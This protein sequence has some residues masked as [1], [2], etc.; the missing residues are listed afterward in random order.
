MGNF[1][2]SV[3][4]AV[5][6][7]FYLGPISLQANSC[8]NVQKYKIRAARIKQMSMGMARSILLIRIYCDSVMQFVYQLLIL[9]ENIYK[10]LWNYQLR[11]L[12]LPWSAFSFS[13][14]GQLGLLK[15]PS[16]TDHY[17]LNLVV[18]LRTRARTASWRH[19][20]E[21]WNKFLE[22]QPIIRIGL[23]LE[24]S[25]GFDSPPCLHNL[26]DAPSL[27]F[28]PKRIRKLFSPSVPRVR[29]I[30]KVHS[31][32]TAY[33][34]KVKQWLDSFANFDIDFPDDDLKFL[35]KDLMT[36]LSPVFF[37]CSLIEFLTCR[38]ER[39]AAICNTFPNVSSLNFASH[40]KGILAST[41]PCLAFAALKVF[42][43]GIP[44][45]RRMA[46]TSS[47]CNFCSQGDDKIEHLVICPALCYL[48]QK[49]TGIRHVFGSKSVICA[50]KESPHLT[51][52]YAM[53]LYVLCSMHA[54]AFHSHAIPTQDSFERHYFVQLKSL[55]SMSSLF[56]FISRWPIFN[57]QFPKP[58]PRKASKPIPPNRFLINTT[59]IRTT[60]LETQ[61][62]QH[63]WFEHASVSTEF[64]S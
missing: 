49:Y 10:E 52:A 46:Q 62:Q 57:N 20:V 41:Q 17:A 58:L 12:R 25:I 54:Y 19:L 7:F 51:I 14:I 36:I 63:G 21:P 6:W 16:F 40:V 53:H 38:A 50:S 26:R 34:N 8:S 5:S 56:P 13:C 32:Q 55:R 59:P 22:S 44:T 35:Q 28:F 15:L 4:W 1:Q 48:F 64:K 47:G 43:S 60:S 23:Q 18:L 31:Q 9:P 24:A 3:M 61:L 37:P 27:S 11:V 29:P 33:C 42:C 45:K 2:G 30:P 39:W